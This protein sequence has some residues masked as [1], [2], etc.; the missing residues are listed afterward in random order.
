MPSRF[1]KNLTARIRHLREQR[2]QTQE[3]FAEHA[4]ISYKYYQTIEAGRRVDLRVSTLERLANAHGLE[5]W[6]LLLPH[7]GEPGVSEGKQARYGKTTRRTK[8]KK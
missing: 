4:Q 8:R 6:E 3:E 7:R 2:G 1:L 5:L